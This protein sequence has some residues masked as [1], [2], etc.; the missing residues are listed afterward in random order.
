MHLE[1]R[2]RYR[3]R[4]LGRKVNHPQALVLVVAV[5]NLGVISCVLALLFLVS[6]RLGE[7]QRQKIAVRG[8]T[9]PGDVTLLVEDAQRFTSADG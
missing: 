2:R 8:P 5:P 4:A 9:R 7:E 1:A 3:L 6:F